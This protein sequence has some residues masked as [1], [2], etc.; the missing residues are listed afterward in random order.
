MSAALSTWSGQPMLTSGP[1][2][3]PVFTGR[4]WLS[5][6]RRNLAAIGT[7]LP[8]GHNKL[9]GTYKRRRGELGPI[10]ARDNRYTADWLENVRY[11]QL[12]GT[13]GAFEVAIANALASCM[14]GNAQDVWPSQATIG[15]AIT[16]ANGNAYKSRSVAK[17]LA[18]L[19]A[20]E[21][22][23]WDH[24]DLH[25][26]H[27]GRNR[28]QRT[29][30]YRV[31]MWVE[32]HQHI[33][34][35]RAFERQQLRLE[36]AAKKNGRQHQRQKGKK[37]LWQQDIDNAVNNGASLAQTATNWYEGLA[38]LEHDYTGKPALYNAAYDAYSTA[39]Q[40]AGRPAASTA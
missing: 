16:K 27:S 28:F 11:A 17:G 21:L 29:C 10:D 18:K 8:N 6:G 30:I 23:D 26:D 33:K 34:E 12:L 5:L 19:R 7:G 39:W 25:G 13:I 22:I 37:P 31:K 32:Y 2:D 24:D 15:E 36:R 38:V 3:A 14:Y 40:R 20:V 9:P 1:A 35:R 4:P